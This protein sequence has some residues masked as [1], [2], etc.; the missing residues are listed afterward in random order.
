MITEYNK[1]E[2]MVRE[3]VRNYYAFTFELTK[4]S[5]SESLYL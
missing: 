1:V 4:S 2:A 3:V 5:K